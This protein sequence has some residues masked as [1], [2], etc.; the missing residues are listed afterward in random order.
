M[1]ALI[2]TAA[3]ALVSA[4]LSAR[5]DGFVT[6]WV[7]NNWGSSIANGRASF[8]VNAGGMG[9]GIVGGELDFGYSPSFFG[10]QNDWGNN[11]LIDLMGNVIVGVPIGGTWGPGLRPYVTT[12][13]G[14][15]RTQW[16]GGTF[17]R[18]S[19][20]NNMLG[21]NAGTGVMGF[22]SNHVGLRGDLRYLRGFKDL[23]TGNTVLDLSGNNQLHTWR[24]SAGLVLR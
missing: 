5:A 23:N 6:P 24:L 20:S 12:G 4:P 7:G 1:K 22:F 13:L 21:W 10:T 15:L 11:T 18:I 3:V 14:L 9:H 17:T 8:G 19:A 2:L 16:D